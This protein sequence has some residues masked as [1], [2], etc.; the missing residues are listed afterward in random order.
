MGKRVL[1]RSLFCAPPYKTSMINLLY[2][3]SDLKSDFYFQNFCEKYTSC[4]LNMVVLRVS[5][6]NIFYL[7][8]VNFIKID[9]CE[10]ICLECCSTD[11]DK[12]R[13]GIKQMKGGNHHENIRK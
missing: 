7:S 3:F 2:Y 13:R 12:K 11:K 1:I 10:L 5:F 9:V 8:F 4:I 6:F